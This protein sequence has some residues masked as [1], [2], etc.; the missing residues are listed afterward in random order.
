MG[1]AAMIK[2]MNRRN[3][4]LS[5]LLL[6]SINVLADLPKVQT[7]D[8]AMRWLDRLEKSPTASTTG[9][10]PLVAVLEHLAQSIEMSMDGF[11]E[12]K[13]AFF[14]NTAGAAAFAYFS[15][16]GKMTHS[17]SEPIPG[18]PAL[19]KQG[20]WLPA[21][22]H[23]RTAIARFNGS[24]AEALRPHFAYGK[25]S[26]SEFALAHVFHIANHQDEIVVPV[27]GSPAMT[28]WPR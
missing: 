1:C 23:L 2:T 27:S 8:E 7:L 6:V 13:S 28:T 21:A 18:A 20:D 22:V 25:L 11:P 12:P 3:V 10:W 24:K 15:W 19:S 9:Q 4:L 16:R 26:K 17:L 5:P 14:Q